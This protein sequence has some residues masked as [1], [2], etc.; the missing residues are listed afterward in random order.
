MR[1]SL[2][3]CSFAL[4][5]LVALLPSPVR[6]EGEEPRHTAKPLLIRD[7]QGKLREATPE[8]INARASAGEH[9]DAHGEGGLAFTGLKRWDLGIYTLIVFGLLIFILSKYAWPHIKEGLEKREANIRSVLD[10]A[11]R[12]REQSVAAFAEAKKQLDAAAQQVKGMIDEARREADALKATEREAGVKDAAA[13]RDRA[14]RDANAER[15][16]MI[17]DVYEKAVKLAALMSE[18]ALRRSV[19]ESDHRRLLDESIAELKD[20]AHKA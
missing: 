11:R 18:K 20:S 6:A 9:G 19:S 7:E 15:D 3:T 17:K 5:A 12:E 1:L 14:K 10:E 8:E 2:Y 4:A 16:A 13:E